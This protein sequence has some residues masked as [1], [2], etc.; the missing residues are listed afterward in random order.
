MNAPE[1]RQKPAS[2]HAEEMAAATAHEAQ[3]VVWALLDEW[4]AGEPAADFDTAVMQRI[5][6]EEHAKAPHGWLGALVIWFRTMNLER[7]FGLATAAVV[8]LLA[9]VLLREPGNV[10]EAIQSATVDP[11][12]SAQ[13]AESALEDMRLLEELYTL[14]APDD[15][16]KKI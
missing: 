12:F 2:Q 3:L 15:H 8:V 1:M 9:L 7:G 4:K 16:Q 11:G 6:E 14:P 13:Q 5:R 10:P